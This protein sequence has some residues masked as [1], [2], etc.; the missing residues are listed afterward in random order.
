MTAV[1]FAKALW[2]F[3]KEYILGGN[4]LKES[5]RNHKK[6]VVVLGIILFMGAVIA[7]G[8]YHIEKLTKDNVEYRSMVEFKTVQALRNELRGTRDELIK[9]ERENYTLRA[10]APTPG[11]CPVLSP[12]TVN[13]PEFVQTD[14]GNKQPGPA[15]KPDPRP[16][17]VIPNRT[18]SYDRSQDFVDFFGN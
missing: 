17:A 4:D 16:P 1:E 7:V 5:W 18:E 14:P 13:T 12:T 3:A 8:Y 2:P 15:P 6:R 10:M 9:L 11:V